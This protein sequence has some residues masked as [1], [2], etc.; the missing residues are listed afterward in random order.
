LGYLIGLLSDHYLYRKLKGEEERGIN[1]EILG[2]LL[3]LDLDIEFLFS[4]VGEILKKIE[5]YN[6][7]L[8]E[9]LEKG[10]QILKE[11]DEF[12]PVGR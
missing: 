9:L 3:E 2:E 11:L 1:L 4:G 7:E 12:H 6:R 10:E 8:G 5:F